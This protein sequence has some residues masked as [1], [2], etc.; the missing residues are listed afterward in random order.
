MELDVPSSTNNIKP[1]GL[2]LNISDDGAYKQP[3]INS[4]DLK[5]NVNDYTGDDK[6]DDAGSNDLENS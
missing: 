1:K 4:D 2:K 6:Q 5:V 3:N